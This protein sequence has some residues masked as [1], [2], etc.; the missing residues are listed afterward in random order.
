MDSCGHIDECAQEIDHSLA[1]TG[2]SEDSGSI[3]TS[4][5]LCAR[6]FHSTLEPRA[7]TRPEALESCATTLLVDEKT[8]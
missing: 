2:E 4:V 3:F 8:V 1:W 7:T 5:C 6:H